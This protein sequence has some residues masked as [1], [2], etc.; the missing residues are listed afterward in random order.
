MISISFDPN[1]ILHDLFQKW[2]NEEI[3]GVDCHLF[4]KK[5]ETVI[6]G[7]KKHKE[8]QDQAFELVDKEREFVRDGVKLKT[9]FKNN[10]KFDFD[11]YKA[12]YKELKGIE[13]QAKALFMQGKKNTFMPDE[14]GELQEIK[15]ATVNPTAYI[16]TEKIR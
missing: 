1:D 6:S 9:V 12:K 14:N 16:A 15:A 4:A 11:Y 10:Y 13:E 5:L 2:E 8:I 3:D 7:I